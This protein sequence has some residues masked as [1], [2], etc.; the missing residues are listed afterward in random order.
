VPR[1]HRAIASLFTP[2]LS[3]GCSCVRP[4]SLRGSRKRPANLLAFIGTGVACFTEGGAGDDYLVT[5]M[6]ADFGRAFEVV[7]LCPEEGNPSYHV[8][9]AADGTYSCEC[10]GFLSWDRCRHVSGLLQLLRAGK[11]DHLPVEGGAR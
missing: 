1:S 11:L 2:T 7:K 6:P 10:K 8:L 5:A 9:L 4:A 3:A